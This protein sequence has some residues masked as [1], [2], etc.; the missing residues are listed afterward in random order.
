MNVLVLGANG[1]LGNVVFRVLSQD[2]NLVV[3]G[4]V[5]SDHIRNRFTS[6]LS[7]SLVVVNNLQDR[8]QLGYIIQRHKPDVVINCVGLPLDNMNESDLLAGFSLFPRLLHV[9]CS[10]NN[11]RL[12]HFSSD[13]VFSGDTGNYSETDL[14]DANDLYGKLKFLGEVEGVNA[15][16]LRT[17]MIGPE[18]G[19]TRGL[20]SWFLSQETDCRCYNRAIF[21]GFPTVIL[22]RILRDVIL[23]N[24]SLHGIYHLASKPISKFDLLDLIRIEYQKKIKMHPDD[25]LVIDRSLCAD[26]F[27]TATGYTP[28]LWEDM[29]KEMRNYNYGLRNYYV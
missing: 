26:R 27:F 10:S 13:G 20:L 22:G 11:I 21:S 25:S 17:S 9:I 18:L 24:R 3:T 23:P 29:V 12:I 15:L 4:T 8:M 16:T 6:V 28:P 19:S 1:L 7:K 14:P 5:R 2:I